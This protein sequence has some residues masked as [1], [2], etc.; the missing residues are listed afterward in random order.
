MS[1]LPIYVMDNA[2]FYRKQYPDEMAMGFIGV[3][4]HF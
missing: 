4:N 1:L 2:W 3:G